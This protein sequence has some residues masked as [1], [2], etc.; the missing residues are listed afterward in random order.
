[1]MWLRILVFIPLFCFIYFLIKQAVQKQAVWGGNIHTLE[2]LNTRKFILKLK[3]KVIEIETNLAILTTGM[4]VMY[5]LQV[6]GCQSSVQST[7]VNIL[8]V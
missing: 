4:F 1:M 3:E 6:I 8:S 7:A 2:S 5:D